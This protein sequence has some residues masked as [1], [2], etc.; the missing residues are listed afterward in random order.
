[1]RFWRSA[2]GRYSHACLNVTNKSTLSLHIAAYENS[3]EAF[4]SDFSVD[5]NIG[6]L[7]KEKLG[8]IKTSKHCF[9]D[10]LM[11]LKSRVML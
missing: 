3:N 6:G 10:R 5:E 8:S 7:K 4:A 9:T 11:V 2:S 1:M